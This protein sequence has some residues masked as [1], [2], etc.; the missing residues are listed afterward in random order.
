MDRIEQHASILGQVCWVG[1][2]KFSPLSQTTRYNATDYKEELKTT[3]GIDNSTDDPEVHPQYSCVLCQ[4]TLVR[5]RGKATYC[6]EECGTTQN[7]TPHKRSNCS[8]CFGIK[9]KAK[10]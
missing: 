7:W 8:F 9:D 3:F 5:S 10:R 4:R 1:D 6:G 2:T